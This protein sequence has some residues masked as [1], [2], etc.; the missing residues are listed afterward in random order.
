MNKHFLFH[1]LFVLWHI[2]IKYSDYIH[3]WA[4]IQTV[5]KSFGQL[6]PSSAQ[7]GLRK[8]KSSFA[9]KLKL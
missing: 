8:T 3:V 9:T 5:V 7:N 6:V 2:H 1:S 4:T